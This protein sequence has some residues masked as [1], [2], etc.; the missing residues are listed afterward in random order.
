MRFRFGAEGDLTAPSA[1]RLAVGDARIIDFLSRFARKLLAPAVARRHPEL[2]SLGFFLRPAELRR[3]VAAMQR[4]DALTFPRGNVFHVP[5]ANVDTIFVYSWALSALAGNHNVVRISE[6]SANAADTVLE[7]L[8]ATLADADPIIGR[9]QRMVTYGRED[10]I[11][12]ALS[13]WADL[14]VIWGGDAAVDTIRRHPLRPSARDLTFPDRTSWA[15]LCTAGWAAADDATRRA[16]V[17]GFT[18]DAYWF[19]QAACSSPRTVFL[20]GDPADADR[21]QDEFLTLLGAVVAERGWTVDPAMAVEKRVNAYGLAAVG[22]ATGLTFAGNAVTGIAL[23][24]IEA[25][26]R[27][28]LGAGAFPFVAVRD[29]ADLVPVMNRQDQTFSHFGFTATQLRDFATALG[30][31]GVDRIVPF[32]SALTFSAVWDG[33]DLPREFTRLTTLQV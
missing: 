27:R 30:G 33:Y 25:L 4:P 11:T 1:D 20:V 28:W 8:N 5:P 13:S 21:V 26:P 12:G 17:L 6:R 16:A 3:A 29:L 15:A 23:A 2:G 10:A 9:T 7:A 14:R 19:D 18:N 24:D 31:R 32:G 22:A